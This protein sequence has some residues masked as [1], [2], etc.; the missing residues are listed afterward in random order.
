MLPTPSLPPSLPPF[1][2]P[3]L[4][5]VRPPSLPQCETWPDDWSAVTVGGSR[6]APFEPTMLVTESGVELL[7]ARKGGREGGREEGSWRTIL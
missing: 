7:T 4:P 2:P 1:L 6:S 5:P 3:S